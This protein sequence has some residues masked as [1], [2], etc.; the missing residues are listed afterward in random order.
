MLALYCLKPRPLQHP[1]DKPI[2][3][4]IE[5]RPDKSLVELFNVG[6]VC[7]IEHRSDQLIAF[8]V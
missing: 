6:Q 7:F 8:S 5:L 3:C 2:E 1:L 4:I